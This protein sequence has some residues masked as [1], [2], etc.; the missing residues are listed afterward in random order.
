ML[1]HGAKKAEQRPT[2]ASCSSGPLIKG[3]GWRTGTGVWLQELPSVV[4]AVVAQLGR[5]YAALNF[6]RLSGSLGITCQ[7]VAASGSV[8]GHWGS[9]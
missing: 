6:D 8:S 5:G 7:G 9:L 1:L 3:S 4:G 2:A